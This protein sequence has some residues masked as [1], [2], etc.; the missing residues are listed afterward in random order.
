MAEYPRGVYKPAVDEFGPTPRQ[1]EAEV[2]F[3]RSERMRLARELEHRA[4]TLQRI[5]DACPAA[6][7]VHSFPD[8][9]YV[10]VNRAL[11]A[12]G[13][14]RGALIGRTPQ[15]LGIWSDP[16]DITQFIHRLE[17]KGRCNG[18]ETTL[19]L[20]G[21]AT[22][23]LLSGEL[24]DIDGRRCV[25]ISS[26]AI[27]RLKN[28]E[29][30]L[31]AAREA[32]VAASRAKSQFLSSMS[33]EIRTPMNA[34]LGMSD[35]LWDTELNAE[36]RRYLDI[37]RSNG[38]ALLEIINDILDLAKV[39]SG[40]LTFEKTEFDLHD[41]INKIG[42]TVAIRTHERR[43]EM[44]VH[45][46]PDVPVQVLG[47]RHRL[48]QILL[49]LLGNAVK[50][51]PEGEIVLTVEVARV[52]DGAPSRNDLLVLRFVVEDAGIGIAPDR[53]GAIF[54]DFTQA[55][56]STTRKYGG[57]G[58]GLAIVRRLTAMY[59]GMVTV[60][61]TLGKGSIFSFTAEFGRVPTPEAVAAPPLSDLAQVRVL[62]ADDTAAN[63]LILSEILA[64]EGAF[65]TCVE[66]GPTALDE[67]KSAA[68]N[69]LAYE[70]LLLDCRMPEMDGIEVAAHITQSIPQSPQPVI[71]MLTSDDLAGTV[72]RAR[73]AGID[74]HLIK[75]IKRRELLDA[76]SETLAKIRRPGAANN[77]IATHAVAVQT[78]G[79]FEAIGQCHILLVDDSADNRL[80]VTAYMRNSPITL[81][82]AENGADAVEQ[83]KRQR[84]DLVLMDIQMP[85]MDGYTATR[86]IRDFEQQAARA[87]TPI[88]ALTASAVGEA[89]DEALKAGCDLHVTKPIKKLTLLSA[90]HN[91]LKRQTGSA[92]NG[93]EPHPI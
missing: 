10:E 38:A 57:T 6:I 48:R 77:L 81:V 25:V 40:Q 64:A 24:V 69:G 46:A 32:A 50:F 87:P 27:T 15:E 93:R 3:L 70:L 37:V 85:K 19:Y 41:L 53:L 7:S 33:H 18:L 68:A 44:A 11:E 56:A 67:I 61:S 47:D 14:A 36:Q 60:E 22:P 43:V 21:K 20:R 55:E 89:L 72:A 76:V 59:G 42:D 91:L 71:L 63:R 79:A 65:V 86:A 66:S 88:I 92:T 75:P 73:A 26:H 45:V 84:F 74:G 12:S 51:T 28:T 34:V 1:L 35:L 17:T 8:L 16:T 31:I 49:N 62:V 90:I 78:A 83:F 23:A 13:F 39:E 9:A 82:E 29:W 30:E 52:P 58:L 54:E 4:R 5:F 2:V 80:L